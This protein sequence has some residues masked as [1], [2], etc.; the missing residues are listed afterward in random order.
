MSLD[1]IKQKTVSAVIW[2][3]IEK[4]TV[5]GASFAISIVLARIL[6]PNDYGLIGMLAI[7]MA[8][9]NLFIESGFAKALIQKQ[10]CT[11]S[12]YSTAFFTN[13]GLSFF[14]Y[15][16]LFISAPY[17]AS[18]YEEP[19]LCS[20]LRVL[21]LNL[22]VGSLN[23]VQRAKLM[24]QMDFKALANINFLGMLT[25]GVIGITMA[26]TGFGVWALV[27]QTLGQTCMMLGLFPRYSKWRPIW[28][29]SKNS[30]NR[31]FGYGSKLLIS[32]VVATIV[33]NISTIAIGKSYKSESL[34][35]YTRATHFT[36]LIAWT[37]ND[38]VG[39]VTFPVLSALQ[40]ER[41]RMI[42]VYRK[43]LFYTA[44]IIFPIMMLLALLARPLVLVLLTEKWMPCV[45]LIQIL[46]FARMFTP[47][48]AINLNLLNAIGRS[49]LF[50]KVDLSKI[51]LSAV[52]LLITI[53]ISVK[54][55]VIGSVVNTF[56]CFFIN[57]YYPGKLFGYGAMSQIK[58]FKYIF[59][60]LVVMAYSVFLVTN[61]CDGCYMQLIVGAIVGIVV[62]ILVCILFKLINIRE[63][64]RMMD[65]RLNKA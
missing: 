28:V 16:I 35:F 18:F 39:T 38:I 51:P 65:E 45:V 58:D 29:F 42:E 60:A 14:I 17:I 64:K 52:I 61:V 48:S 34:G 50:M 41:E 62:Y 11:D 20:L 1:N 4:I 31:L 15:L 54:A 30:F 33:N 26:Y 40:E 59:L 44:L 27:G 7:F 2:N 43:S 63:L 46:C 21:S 36:D 56:I 8:L 23:I 24:A 25:G 57:A 10:D 13:V 6:S 32:G 53:P 5:K 22:I 3:T 49:D 9:S 37:V 12:D 19:I 47:L 55:I